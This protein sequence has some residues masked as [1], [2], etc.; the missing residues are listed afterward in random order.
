MFKYV[1]IIVAVVLLVGCKKDNGRLD[2]HGTVSWKNQPI[3]RGI[4]YFT[5]DVK[6]GA[7]GPQGLAFIKDGKYD[8]RFENSRGCVA[9]P[10]L[11]RIEACDGKG[12]SRFKPF[13]SLMF[14]EPPVVSI[15]VPAEGGEINLVVPESAKPAPVSRDA[16]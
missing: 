7:K 11:A 10:H 9:G 12:V 16:E 4:I 13:G 15:D 5:P 14:T 3:A 6:K 2:I 1:S 8:T